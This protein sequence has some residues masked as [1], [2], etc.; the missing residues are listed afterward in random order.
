M[1]YGTH[2][3]ARGGGGGGGGLRASRGVVISQIEK[4]SDRPP[5]LMAIHFHA[6]AKDACLIVE[7]WGWKAL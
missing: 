6:R 1:I 4:H 7:R 3:I 2:T 5:R